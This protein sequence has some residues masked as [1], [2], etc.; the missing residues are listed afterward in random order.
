MSTR[1][2]IDAFWAAMRANDWI[3]AAECFVEDIAVV[4][5]CSGE[6]IVGRHDYA[7]L[8]AAYPSTTGS[9]TFDIHRI[10]VDGQTAVSE[11]TASD[12][13]QSARVIAFSMVRDDQIVEQV[14]YWPTAYD[15]PPGRERF[16]RPTG[17]IP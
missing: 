17:R 1:R 13:Q 7:E 10:V 14:E 12:G 2:V 15:P 4:W 5:P 8:Q 16:T 9:W 11:A 6:L 3:R